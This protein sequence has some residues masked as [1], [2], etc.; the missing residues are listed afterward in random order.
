M[1]PPIRYVRSGGASIAYQ[2]IG[3]AAIDILMILIG[4][5]VFP[6]SK[7]GCRTPSRDEVWFGK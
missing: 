2:V 3:D 1:A 7:S 6:L 5:L 4:R